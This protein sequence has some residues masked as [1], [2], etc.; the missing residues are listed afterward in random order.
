MFLVFDF[1]SRQQKGRDFE[2]VVGIMHQTASNV[3]YWALVL[4][5]F[6]MRGTKKVNRCFNS[7]QENVLGFLV[8]F[9][10]SGEKKWIG[11]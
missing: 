8:L 1:I 2:R 6:G 10:D 9:P 7:E 3:H 4:V 11:E 5:T